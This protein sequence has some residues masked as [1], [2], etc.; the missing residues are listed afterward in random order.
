MGNPRP[1]ARHTLKDMDEASLRVVARRRDIAC[2][3]VDPVQALYPNSA[4][5]ADGSLVD[6]GR[7]ASV[8][9]AKYADWLARLR[10][11]CER[12]VALIFDEIFV[13]FRLAPGGAQEYFG[14]RA[15]MVTY[16]KTVAGGLPVGVLCGPHRLMKRYRDARP[17]DIGFSPARATCATRADRPAA[18][19]M[20]TAEPTGG[21]IWHACRGA[22]TLRV[23][24]TGR[25]AHVGYVHQGVNAFEHM[26]R[27]AEPLT[28]SRTSC[29]VSAR[30]SRSRATRPAARCSWWAVR[31][32]PAPGSTRCPG[33]R[34]SRSTGAST[35]R[36]TSTGSW[37]L[38]G[39]ITEAAEAIGARGRDRG[40]AGAALRQHRARATRPPRGPGCVSAVEGAAPRLQMCPGVLDTR[41]YSQL[42][43]P[44]FAYGGGG[45]DVSHGPGGVHRR[46]GRCAAAPPSMRSLPAPVAGRPYRPPRCRRLSQAASESLPGGASSG[47]SRGPDPRVSG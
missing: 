18:L 8:D 42:G 28:P 9:R 33:R 5:P 7:R 20:L 45:L 26:I 37:R 34:G 46:R 32:A 3:L 21:L 6:S 12:G 19:A 22:I 29:S 14:V 35:P 16:G 38:T 27:I 40:A 15:D 2:V 24:T 30:A 4:A 10:E 39:T 31:R 25:E 36:R 17:A 44:A 23:T 41:W 1:A 47:K 43:I 13:G 11:V